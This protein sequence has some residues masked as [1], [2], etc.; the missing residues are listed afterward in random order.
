MRRNHRRA[1][2]L[3]IYIQMAVWLCLRRLILII[4]MGR[5][6]HSHLCE[7]LPIVMR[8]EFHLITRSC[9]SR[10]CPW[11]AGVQVTVIAGVPPL[12]SRCLFNDSH[13]GLKLQVTASCIP[14]DWGFRSPWLVSSHQRFFSP[15][16][17]I[18]ISPTSRLLPPDPMAHSLSG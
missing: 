8:M 2:L 3:Y 14:L 1:A 17:L 9:M 7:L 12:V 10:K 18:S 6:M 11:R 16:P 4:Y 5:A 15:L 13:K